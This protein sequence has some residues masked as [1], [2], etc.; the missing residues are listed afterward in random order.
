M[1]LG[2]SGK[3]FISGDGTAVTE[4]EIPGL[5]LMTTVGF[6]VC[7]KDAD[8]QGELSQTVTIVH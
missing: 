3:T 7:A 2:I 4:V 8:G 6:R 1:G 5:P